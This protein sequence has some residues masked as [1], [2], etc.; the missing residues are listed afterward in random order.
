[1]TDLK[2]FLASKL[3]DEESL[4][5]TKGMADWKV[6]TFGNYI[7]QQQKPNFYGR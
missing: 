4:V 2:K 1:L 7:M 5:W 3:L 6:N